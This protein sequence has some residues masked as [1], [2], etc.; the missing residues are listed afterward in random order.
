MFD[1]KY[2]EYKFLDSLIFVRK[3][4]QLFS[5]FF[6]RFLNIKIQTKQVTFEQRFIVCAQLIPVKPVLQIHM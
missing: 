3:L 6:F 4:M 2:F 1:L 5:F